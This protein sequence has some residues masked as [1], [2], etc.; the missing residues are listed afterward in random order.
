MADLPT[1]AEMIQNL[2]TAVPQVVNGLPQ[3][4]KAKVAWPSAGRINALAPNNI[5]EFF[6]TYFDTAHI[7]AIEEAAAR[8]I[9]PMS[10][11]KLMILPIIK[12]YENKPAANFVKDPQTITAA[13]A[14][15]PTPAPAAPAP[16][17]APVPA[18]VAAT[19]PVTAPTPAVTPAPAAPAPA[20][21]TVMVPAA[22][23]GSF[24]FGVPGTQPPQPQLP[25]QQPP[26]QPPAAAAPPAQPPAPSQGTVQNPQA[27]GRLPSG[28]Y[29]NEDD[30]PGP[31]K[32]GKDWGKLMEDHP[33]LAG[34]GIGLAVVA[35]KAATGKASFDDLFLFLAIGALAGFMYDKFN[36][37]PE[38]RDRP[39]DSYNRLC[40]NDGPRGCAP[41]DLP[42]Q[43]RPDH[44]RHFRHEHGC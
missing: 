41:S 26:Q 19:P 35:A 31:K 22:T 27:P 43:Y 33:M 8:D 32:K 36:K 40:H 28:E 3:D 42:P 1:T 37:M 18:P 34:M 14:P 25:P 2:K 38:N 24:Q 17:P 7:K 13:A 30:A 15:A 23:I 6:K 5:E 4:I 21:A 9:N 20:P 16:A 11:L 29:E 39:N 44:G 12:P 10:P